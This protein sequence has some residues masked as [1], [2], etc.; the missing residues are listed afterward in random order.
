MYLDTKYYIW[1]PNDE[2][3]KN[4]DDYLRF[5][6]TK[7]KFTV[8]DDD[9]SYVSFCLSHQK[10][11]TVNIRAYISMLLLNWQIYIVKSIQWFSGV[12]ITPNV[13]LS[14]YKYVPR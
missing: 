7:R 2:H 12:L 9:L 10:D 6:G 14:T 11:V 3:E 8:Y 4:I 13:T 5:I 1:A